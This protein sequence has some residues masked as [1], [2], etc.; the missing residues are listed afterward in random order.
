MSVHQANVIRISK[1]LPHPN[2]ESLGICQIGGFSVCVRLEDFKAGDLAIY[3]EP[4]TICPDT[5]EF[6]FLGNNKKIRVRRFRGYPSQGLLI[7]AP[8]EAK[9]GDDYFDTLLLRHYEPGDPATMGGDNESGPPGFYPTYDVEN[10]RKHS[11]WFNGV[12][13]VVASE[14]LHG[15]NSSFTSV[16]GAMHCRSRT[17]WKKQDPD[18]LWWVALDQNPWIKEWCQQHE[19]LVLYGEVFGQVQNL[20]YGANGRQYFFRAF[21][22]WNTAKS[23][24]LDF[25]E[26]MG[27]IVDAGKWVPVLYRGPF[28]AELLLSLSEGP[29]TIPGANHIREGVVVRPVKEMLAGHGMNER[30]QLKIVSST[31]LEKIK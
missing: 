25:D 24:W 8:P 10:Y 27:L 15:C 11:R 3:I 30:L 21:D 4:D 5:P 28:D 6:A 23:C 2:A 7:K 26:A 17:N 19:G 18:C 20:K 14:K 1:V 31:Y 29:T 9:E 16:S 12:G 22:I 13:E